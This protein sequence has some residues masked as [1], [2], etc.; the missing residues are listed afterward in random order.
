[1]R[2]QFSKRV[3][4]GLGMFGMCCLPSKSK[5]ML[6]DWNR[7]RLNFFLTGDH[8]DEVNKFSYLGTGNSTDRCISNK[9]SSRIQ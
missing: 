7:S 1:M 3:N 2:N 4:D 5:L 8:L 6:R 9:L